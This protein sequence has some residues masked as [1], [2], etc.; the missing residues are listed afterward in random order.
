MAIG[1]VVEGRYIH[2]PQRRGSARSDGRAITPL[3]G[4]SGVAHRRGGR[5][6]QHKKLRISYDV[7]IISNFYYS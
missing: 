3:T 2:R 1:V 4:M 5:M 7:G 6:H